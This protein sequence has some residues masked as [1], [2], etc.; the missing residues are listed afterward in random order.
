M[1][2]MLKIQLGEGVKNSSHVMFQRFA[3]DAKTVYLNMEQIAFIEFNELS[4]NFKLNA[5][6]GTTPI[7]A[8]GISNNTISGL[9][10]FGLYDGNYEDITFSNTAK[11][12]YYR[13][14]RELEAFFGMEFEVN[15]TDVANDSG[16]ARSLFRSR[17]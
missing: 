6:M 5:N 15:K 4:I 14:K 1:A 10:K 8:D 2:K 13:I 12:E 17:V 11:V 9:C 16:I 3:R 7:T